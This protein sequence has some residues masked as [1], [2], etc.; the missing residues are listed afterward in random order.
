MA[1]RENYFLDKDIADLD[2]ARHQ[3]ERTEQSRV[4]SAQFEKILDALPF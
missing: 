1:R 2:L 3:G 4:I